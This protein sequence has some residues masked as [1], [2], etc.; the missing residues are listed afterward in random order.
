GRPTP[1]VEPEPDFSDLS[2]Q[3]VFALDQLLGRL[4]EATHPH[5]PGRPMTPRET[6]V[7]DALL[8]RV[9]S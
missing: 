2:P 7:L 4:Q 5:D 3:E 1:P 9:R 6:T 8:A